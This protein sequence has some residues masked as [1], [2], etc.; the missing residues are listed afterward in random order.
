MLREPAGDGAVCL[1][2]GGIMGQLSECNER[3]GR[4]E[5]SIDVQRRG[6]GKKTER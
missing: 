6:G 5:D 2:T 1:I 4:A 3:R